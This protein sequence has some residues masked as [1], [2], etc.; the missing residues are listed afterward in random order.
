MAEERN[1][2]QGDAEWVVDN[3]HYHGISNTNADHRCHIGR[4][5]NYRLVVIT[6]LAVETIVTVYWA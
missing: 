3:G 6:D 5:G 4:I 1:V 2:Y